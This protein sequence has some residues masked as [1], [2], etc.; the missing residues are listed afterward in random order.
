MNDDTVV[1]STKDI[2]KNKTVDWN[3]LGTILHAHEGLDHVP[4]GDN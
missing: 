4:E 2:I 3:N 1:D